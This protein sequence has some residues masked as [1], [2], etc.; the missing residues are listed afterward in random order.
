MK[1]SGGTV[2]CKHGRGLLEGRLFSGMPRRAREIRKESGECRG[3]IARFVCVFLTCE[4]QM[5]V[6]SV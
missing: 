3:V 6:I 4:F 5:C 2:F 1:E